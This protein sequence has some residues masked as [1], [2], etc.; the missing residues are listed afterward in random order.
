MLVVV[1]DLDVLVGPVAGFELVVVVVD[2]VAL[3][4]RAEAVVVVVD[5]V[6]SG[7]G[8]MLVAVVVDLVISAATPKASS[9]IVAISMATNIFF[10]SNFLSI[11]IFMNHACPQAYP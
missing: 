8:F 3:E 11:G 7:L 4:P 6:T 9:I 1:V 2:W 5:L 10:I